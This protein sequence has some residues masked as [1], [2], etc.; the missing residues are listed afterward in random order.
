MHG[1]TDYI[2][3]RSW[4]DTITI[5]YV[6]VDDAYQRLLAKRG[7]PLR[8]SGPD[9]T[10]SDREVITVALIIETFF[11][12]TKRWATPSSPNTIRTCFPS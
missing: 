2:T 10:F 1:L 12:V 6:Q 8:S 4:V 5:W 3:E 9:P 7:R 11:K